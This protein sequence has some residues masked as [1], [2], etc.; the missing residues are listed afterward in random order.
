MNMISQGYNFTH[1]LLFH[2]VPTSLFKLGVHFGQFN[3]YH[4]TEFLLWKN[5][6]QSNTSNLLII[7]GD[8]L[9]TTKHSHIICN[10]PHLCVIRYANG[11]YVVLDQCPFMAFGIPITFVFTWRE[12]GE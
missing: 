5:R 2:S 4:I 8:A 12:K 10:L 3:K 7:S 9:N 11:C 6:R 1:K